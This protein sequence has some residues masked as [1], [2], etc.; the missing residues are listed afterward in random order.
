LTQSELDVVM[1][2]RKLAREAALD[3]LIDTTLTLERA[4]REGLVLEDKAY[5]DAA[6]AA[7][8]LE[9]ARK[10]G[11]P[12]PPGKTSLVVDH[13][14]VKD[15]PAPQA[16][17][18]NR[19]LLEKLRVAALA[20]TRIP[21]AW[22]QLGAPGELW[23]IG[24]HEEYPYEVLPPDARDT[25]AGQVSPIA[26]GDGGLHLFQ[27]HERKEVPPPADE[28]RAILRAKLREGARIERR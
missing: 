23:H 26:A 14:W 9:L 10:I 8:E 27:V 5:D 21:A 20:G 11:L 19:K 24:D 17:A 16:R 1:S 7:F 4:K 25:P 28:V 22:K 18:A 3:E 6:R 15:A 2:T 13:A 12:L